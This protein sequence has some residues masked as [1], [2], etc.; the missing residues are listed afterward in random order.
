[1]AWGSKSSELVEPIPVK[2]GDQSFSVGVRVSARA[3]RI[4]LKVTDRGAEVVLPRWA[5][6]RDA[7][8][9]VMSNQAWLARHVQRLAASMEVSPDDSTVLIEGIEY[10]LVHDLGDK[11]LVLIEGDTVHVGGSEPAHAL[12]AWLQKLARERFAAIIEDRSAEMGLFPAR[13]SIRDQKTKWGACTSRG[14]VTFNW[15]LVMAPPAVLDY[16][17][18]HELAHL[19]ELNHS[20]RYWAIVERFCPEHVRHRK[21]LRDNGSRLKLPAS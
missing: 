15:R 16:V 20:P 19:K 21:W 3:K 17:V 12:S 14:T 1:M 9:A 11:P 13:V 8:Q 7:H 2:H 10:K 6:R 4:R 18:V 5:R